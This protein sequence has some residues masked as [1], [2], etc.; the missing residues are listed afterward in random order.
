MQ[1]PN[2]TGAQQMPPRRSRPCGKDPT[3]VVTKPVVIAFAG[4]ND[5]R[6]NASSQS[7][8]SIVRGFGLESDKPVAGWKSA[9]IRC[10][11]APCRCVAGVD[12]WRALSPV[13]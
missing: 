12:V 11:I 5:T 1:M 10:I 8:A 7:V 4:G 6:A 2:Y 9:C 13:E 3:I